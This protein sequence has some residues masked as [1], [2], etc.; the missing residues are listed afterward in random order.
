MTEDTL[1]DFELVELVDSLRQVGGG[2]DAAVTVEIIPW[3]L[4]PESAPATSR[5][6]SLSTW[7]TI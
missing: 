1:L 5:C 6:T 3:E 2:G 7:T 4:S